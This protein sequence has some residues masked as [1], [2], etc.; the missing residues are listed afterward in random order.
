MSIAASWIQLTEYNNNY[1]YYRRVPLYQHISWTN[2]QGLKIKNFNLSAYCVAICPFGGPIAIFKKPNQTS[3]LLGLEQT[4]TESQMIT[5]Y[6]ASCKFHTKID[7]SKE[8]TI[9][10]I[11]WTDDMKLM[12][13][14]KKRL[15]LYSVNGDRYCGPWITEENTPNLSS[16]DKKDIEKNPLFIARNKKQQQNKKKEEESS[17]VNVV[18]SPFIPIPL[19]SEE[20]IKSISMFGEGIALFTSKKRLLVAYDL[21]ESLPFHEY[22][23]PDH[24]VS[25]H[26]ELSSVVMTVVP[27]FTNSNRKKKNGNKVGGEN[28][29][30]G[31]GLL[32]FGE[33]EEEGL[34]DMDDEEEEEIEEEEEQSKE[35][36]KEE[37]EEKDDKKKKKKKKKEKANNNNTNNNFNAKPKVGKG[38]LVLL[39]PPDRMTIVACFS[40]SCKDSKLNLR[41]KGQV[42]EKEHF[43]FTKISVSPDFKTIAA[44]HQAS[45]TLFVFDLGLTSN[46]LKFSTGISKFEYEL[47]Q[48]VYCGSES[49]LLYWSP[50]NIGGGDQSLLLLV[51]C[52]GHYESFTFEG[53]IYLSQEIDACRYITQQSVE[54][55]ERIPESIVEIFRIGSLSS[56]ALLYDAYTDFLQEKA[57]SLKTIREIKNKELGD[58]Q[59]VDGLSD[60]VNKCIDAACR[61]FDISLQ[62]QLLNAAIY[63]KTFMKTTIEEA[64]IFQLK[65]KYIRL[66]NEL[67]NRA[68]IPMTYEQMITLTPQ[69]LVQR[70][71]EMH[72]YLLAFKICDYLDLSK[73]KVLEH[74]AKTKIR[75]QLTTN[76]DQQ[77]DES[78][79]MK[80]RDSI[81]DNL[82]KFKTSVSFSNI[83]MEAFKVN[84]PKLA[85]A[86]LEIDANPSDQIKLYL[87]MHETLNALDKAQKSNDTDLLYIVILYLLKFFD[88]Y[89]MFEMIADKPQA[90]KLFVSYSIHLGKFKLL[91]K[92]YT[93][94]KN[95]MNEDVASRENGFIQVRHAYKKFNDMDDEN[96][97]KSFAYYLEKAESKFGERKV[98]QMDQHFCLK[99]RELYGLQMKLEE[100]TD[101]EEF[102]G[103]TL[104]ETLYRVMIS[105]ALTNDKKKKKQK[106]KLINTLRKDFSLSEKRYYYAKLKAYI[107]LGYWKKLEKFANEK[108]SPIGYVPFVES[109]LEANKSEEAC[110]YIALIDHLETKVEYWI[111]LLKFKEAIEAAFEARDIGLLEYIKKKTK[112]SK[113]KDTIE[114]CIAQLK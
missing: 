88:I 83:A 32:G 74:W 43:G 99:E 114:N 27:N 60:A 2:D 78:S 49:M 38:P 81:I 34:L 72:N 94:L 110:K 25:S 66:M 98:D 103:A 95:E 35:E 10:S 33:E 41:F 97:E 6:N 93:F 109:C 73:P 102:V 36:N 91:D 82:G 57:T 77:Q 24:L 42:R 12:C 62:E 87:S 14:T 86:L 53:P 29:K 8:D 15:F 96:A 7:L 108:K 44:F 65:C 30:E 111:S 84:K 4:S 105:P 50:D 52:F 13:L 39:C 79:Q 92:F 58:Q 100:E 51:N 63:G 46:Y 17:N 104:Q 23:F 106:K 61:E 28:G 26:S 55:F 37:D 18:Q 19:Q 22:P 107:H 67:R 5:I 3:N 54:I 76:N 85:K 59:S 80:L 47:D 20:E 31:V 56:S 11:G 69:V 75:S 101:G 89:Y 71:S 16:S 1:F 48:L 68:D 9:L 21:T 45:G 64:K 90:R 113:T 40:Q 70:L 112:N